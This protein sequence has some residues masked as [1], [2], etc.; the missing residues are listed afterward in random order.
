MIERHQPT[1]SRLWN[2]RGSAGHL[3]LLSLFFLLSGCSSLR[4]VSQ[5]IA[6]GQYYILDGTSQIIRFEFFPSPDPDVFSLVQTLE[7]KAPASDDGALTREVSRIFLLV[8]KDTGEIRQCNDFPRDIGEHTRAFLPRLPKPGQTVEVGTPGDSIFSG[9]ANFL[10]RGVGTFEHQGQ[11]I[12]VIILGADLLGREDILH[13]SA[14]SGIILY[15]RFILP[16][17]EEEYRLL[18]T[19]I[20]L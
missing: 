10:H 14:K 18:E 19:N 11:K 13:Y 1:R 15:A 2:R 20:P 3:A 4:S 9:D 17:G 12:P 16:Y 8:D 6:P 7:F 5:P